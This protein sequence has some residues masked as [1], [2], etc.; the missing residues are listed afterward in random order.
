MGPV[1][2]SQRRSPGV[3]PLHPAVNRFSE[4]LQMSCMLNTNKYFCLVRWRQLPICTQTGGVDG[5]IKLLGPFFR[6]ATMN[7]T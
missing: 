2:P 7:K 5:G 4:T 1:W 6:G 3:T